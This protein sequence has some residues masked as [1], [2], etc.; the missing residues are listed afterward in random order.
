MKRNKANNYARTEATIKLCFVEHVF[1]L[2]LI[3][4]TIELLCRA[5]LAIGYETSS[6]RQVEKEGR[7]EIQKIEYLKNE[8][9]FLDEIK[10]IFKILSLIPAFWSQK[11]I[12]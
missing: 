2:Y 5:L 10:S 4:Y 6:G 1:F 9:S 8:K 3:N 7:T 12:Y 11:Y